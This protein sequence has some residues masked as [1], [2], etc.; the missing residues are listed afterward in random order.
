[1][2]NAWQIH[3][4]DTM[5]KNPGKSLKECLQMAKKTYVKGAVSNAV[6]TKK[7]KVSRKSKKTKGTRKKRKGSKKKTG[8]KSKK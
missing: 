2:A 5:R 8:K 6:T 7:A 4:K 1:M 3:V